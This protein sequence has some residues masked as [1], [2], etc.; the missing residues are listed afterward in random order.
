MAQLI[1]TTVNGKLEVTGET[2][3]LGNITPE[4]RQNINF[5]G[6]NPIASLEEDTTETWAALGTGVAYISGDDK[7]SNQP[8]TY[9][10]I[11][12]YVYNSVVR[13]I[14]YSQSIQGGMFIRA[15]IASGWYTDWI[16][17]HSDETP[18]YIKI[19]KTSD[20]ESMSTSYSYFEPFHGGTTTTITRGN[21]SADSYT[22]DT[23]G[24]RSDYV[25]RGIYIGEGIHT[26]RVSCTVRLVNN[27]DSRMAHSLALYRLRD[28]TSTRIAEHRDSMAYGS[29][30]LGFSTITTVEEGDFLFLQVWKGVKANVVDIIGGNCTQMV[31]EVIR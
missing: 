7:V 23:F 21:L 14:W 15:G 3:L 24:D 25:V 22:F 13:Q 29:I 8:Y 30:S 18:Q 26:V 27:T 28:G 5:I 1:D 16:K 4:T 9:G 6:T 11:E 10:F 31:V 20:T 2:N 17:M 12:N 19:Y